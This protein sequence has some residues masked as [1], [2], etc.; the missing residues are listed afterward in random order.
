MLQRWCFRYRLQRST[1]T[2]FWDG[3]NLGDLMEKSHEILS[4][5]NAEHG[6]VTTAP[7]GGSSL[8]LTTAEIDPKEP[9]PLPAA[10]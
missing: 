3:D 2:A 7:L 9:L 6:T 1:W 4:P 5:S 10:H 8:W